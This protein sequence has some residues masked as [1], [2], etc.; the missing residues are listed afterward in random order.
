MRGMMWEIKQTRCCAVRGALP[1]CLIQ[2]VC[3]TKRTEGRGER[4]VGQKMVGREACE[5]GEKG[6]ECWN[7]GMS[8]KGVRE[9]EGS[10]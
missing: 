5:A 6:R 8:E 2:L 7:C 3:K 1:P 10:L 9:M 4:S